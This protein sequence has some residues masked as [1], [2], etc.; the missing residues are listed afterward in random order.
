[1]ASAG[2]SVDASQFGHGLL[3]YSLLEGLKGASLR[4]GEFADVRMLFAY[5]EKRVPELAKSVGRVQRPVVIA[6]DYSGSF[7]IGKFSGIEQKQIALSNPKPI[8]LRPNFRNSALKTDN[9]KLTQ[10]L[11]K[12][13]KSIGDE[14]TGGGQ[15]RIAFADADE[16][17]NAVI[18]AGS[19]SVDGDQV[20]ISLVLLKN[21]NPVGRTTVIGSIN[22]L[23]GLTLRILKTIERMLIPSET[24]PGKKTV[25]E[26]KAHTKNGVSRKPRM[27]ALR[28][29]HDA[30]AARNDR[31]S[32]RRNT[33][34]SRVSFMPELLGQDDKLTIIRPR[35]LLEEKPEAASDFEKRLVEFLTSAYGEEKSD[36]IIYKDVDELNNAIRLEWSYEE[37]STDSY[38]RIYFSRNGEKIL[39]TQNFSDEKGKLERMI[40]GVSKWISRSQNSLREKTRGLEVTPV[41]EDLSQYIGKQ[42]ALLIATDV[43]DHLDPLDNPVLDICTIARI[44]EERYG[45][46]T[47]VA[48]GK[49]KRQIDLLIRQYAIK[50]YEK[51]SELLIFIAG[52]GSYDRVFETGYLA[53]KESIVT[54]SDFNSYV[55]FSELRDKINRIP[56]DHT[57]LVLDTCNSGLINPATT[58]RIRGRLSRAR[59]V[60]DRLADKTRMVTASTKRERYVSDGVPGEHSPFA[61]DF[62]SVLMTEGGTD[63]DGI[64]ITSEFESVLLKNAQQPR[65]GS[66]S[67]EDGPS[68]DFVLLLLDE[69]QRRKR[70]ESNTERSVSGS[71]S[72][73]CKC[74]FQKWGKETYE[75]KEVCAAPN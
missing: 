10:K 27:D 15:S 61:R 17:R 12:R 30:Y 48:V 4:D 65:F 38:L 47:E 51:D 18:P 45:F 24:S 74:A 53:T 56:I 60:K 50:T 70:K 31:F 54:E 8:V 66:L 72:N 42:Y 23:D 43:Y 36:K 28:R 5:A 1:M 25:G 73:P 29:T 3:T 9:L 49:T 14:K 40:K 20:E 7:D 63:K 62:I 6:P 37:D 33:E 59:F 22:D 46:E 68:S 71:L 44:L 21:D 2:V 13:L 67:P 41:A 34:F 52:H 75:P 58:K 11:T 55:P 32:V 35:F 16:L 57:W 19:Y 26:F 69:E 39:E 64:L